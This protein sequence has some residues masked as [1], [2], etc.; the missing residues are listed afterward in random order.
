[1][2]DEWTHDF[3]IEFLPQVINWIGE[4]LSP[5]QVFDIEDLELWALDAGWKEPERRREQE[6]Q[7]AS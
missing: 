6:R 5:E 1:M 2:L 7:D 4:R 3:G